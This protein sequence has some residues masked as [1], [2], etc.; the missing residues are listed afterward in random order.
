[1]EAFL[2]VP[3]SPYMN[4]GITNAVCLTLAD[5]RVPSA[6]VP[7]GV[8]DCGHPRRHQPQEFWAR[9][10]MYPTRDSSLHLHVGRVGARLTC[11]EGAL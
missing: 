8:R 3:A 5:N 6:Q 4:D 2:F 9:Q 1:M 11:K 7:T 10:G